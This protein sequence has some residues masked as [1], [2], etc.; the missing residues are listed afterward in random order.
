MVHSPIYVSREHATKKPVDFESMVV[1]L[2]K[3]RLIKDWG[4]F[5]EEARS[6]DWQGRIHS[7]LSCVREAAGGGGPWCWLRKVIEK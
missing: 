4:N 1:G 3:R 2:L 5:V 6:N 7:Y